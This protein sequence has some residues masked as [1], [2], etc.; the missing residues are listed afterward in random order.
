M[1][2]ARVLRLLIVAVVILHAASCAEASSTDVKDM[3]QGL[4]VLTWTNAASIISVVGSFSSAKRTELARKLVSNGSCS[5]LI[6]Q[7]IWFSEVSVI[8]RHDAVQHS[9]N[10]TL[11]IGVERVKNLMGQTGL[12]LGQDNDKKAIFALGKAIH[13]IQSFYAH[14]NYVELMS[15]KQRKYKNIEDVPIFKIWKRSA[16]IKLNQLK[17]Q[18]LVSACDLSISKPKCKKKSLSRKTLSKRNMQAKAGKKEYK[19]WQVDGYS[20]AVYL[21][22]QASTQFIRFM[23]SEFPVLHKKCNNDPAVVLPIG[24]TAK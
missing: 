16:E 5:E 18:G 17:G 15:L 21:A 7:A 12:Y 13:L 23:F 14:T 20:A 8:G 2:F 3:P 9:L 19:H 11:Q 4:K 6:S 22:E 1:Y 10:G 24:F